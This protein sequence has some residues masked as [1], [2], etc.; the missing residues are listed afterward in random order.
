MCVK[1][2]KKNPIK[3]FIQTMTNEVEIALLMGN[4]AFNINAGTIK[5][6]PP[7]PIN[8]IKIPKKNPSVTI[9]G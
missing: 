8:P 9:N 1:S 7:A 3:E 6:P 2:P 5:N 4:F